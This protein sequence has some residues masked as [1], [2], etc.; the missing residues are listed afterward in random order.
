MPGDLILERERERERESIETVRYQ[1]IHLLCTLPC[2]FG[3]SI[4]LD[5]ADGEDSWPEL[6]HQSIKDIHFVKIRD[7]EMTKTWFCG[8]FPRSPRT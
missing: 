5:T 1:D 7:L 8:S 4:M 3:F 6:R 2:T